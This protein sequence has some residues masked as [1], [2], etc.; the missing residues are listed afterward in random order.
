MIIE[1]LQYS[2]YST[3]LQTPAIAF[4]VNRHDRFISLI[5]NIRFFKLDATFLNTG[6][7][8][9]LVRSPQLTSKNYKIAFFKSFG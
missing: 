8:N 9:C 4:Y 6:K 7:E 1:L 5:I 2:Y 3:T